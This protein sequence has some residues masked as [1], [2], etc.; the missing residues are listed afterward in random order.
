MTLKGS[1]S[2]RWGGVLAKCVTPVTGRVL[3]RCLV[4]HF[5][6]SFPPHR[7]LLP[8]PKASDKQQELGQLKC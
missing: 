6:C 5:L 1:L 7:C 8:F 3:G 2:V 4:Q